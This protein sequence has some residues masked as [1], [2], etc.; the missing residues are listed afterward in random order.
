MLI[1]DIA[2]LKEYVNVDKN[3]SYS[4][5]REA[6]RIAEQRYLIPILDT[7]QYSDLHA[8][9][10]AN[11]LN[12]EQQ[13]LLPYCRRVIANVAM[14]LVYPNLNVRESEMGIQQQKSRE[15][16]SEP[17]NKW[18]YQ[19]S[20]SYYLANGSQAVEELY[21]FLQENK[22]N[23][24]LWVNSKGFSE[25]NELCIRNNK[26]LGRYFNTKDSVR[27]YVALQPYIRLAEKQIKKIVPEATF[28]SIKDTIKGTS[29]TATQSQIED[30]CI[31]IAYTAFYESLSFLSYEFSPTGV[32]ISLMQDGMA[33]KR[34]ISIEEKK[35]LLR[36]A[37]ISKN[38]HIQNLIDAY[39]TT[40]QTTSHDLLNAHK[41]DFWV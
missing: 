26:E 35:M 13:I 32:S 24:P 37:E 8:D 18:R 5:L 6:I 20:R 4:S 21:I 33:N 1:R 25:Y 29:N 28:N 36:K 9:L 15:G 39:K 23:Y 30:V 7:P 17:A 3:I 34:T 2:E 16:T 10:T 12:T 22:A 27:M 14:Y 11:A 31:A 19:E 40:E 38:E 41:K